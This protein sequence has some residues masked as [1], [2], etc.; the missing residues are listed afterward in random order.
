MVEGNLLDLGHEA[1]AAARNRFDKLSSRSIFAKP[2]TQYRHADG[3]VVLFYD[4][5][6]PDLTHQLILVDK[7]TSLFHEQKQEIE[8]LGFKLNRTAIV[9]QTTLCA[10]ETKTLKVVHFS[11]SVAH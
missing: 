7:L 11:V 9:E 5:V 2:L 1:I 3:D 10:V 8:N 6:W 4:R